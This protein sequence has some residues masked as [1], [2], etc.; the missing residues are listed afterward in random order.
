MAANV[1]Q[2]FNSG[3]HGQGKV[4]WSHIRSKVALRILDHRYG[5]RW[6]DRAS[7]KQCEPA[8]L[9]LAHVR[10][11]LMALNNTVR[12]TSGSPYI[13]EAEVRHRFY[14][15][16]WERAAQW[17]RHGVGCALSHLRGI[18]DAAA[19]AGPEGSIGMSERH[20]EFGQSSCTSW[21]AC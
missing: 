21:R 18:A 6:P 20:V 12:P 14:K 17:E 8:G 9:N 11:A 1:E 13:M 2:V 16:C 10:Q 7:W 3:Q 5:S 15:T 4:P 19:C